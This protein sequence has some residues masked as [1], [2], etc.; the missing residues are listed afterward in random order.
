[1]AY[2]QQIQSQSHTTTFLVGCLNIHGGTEQQRNL[3]CGLIKLLNLDICIITETWLKED[4]SNE[5]KKS[6][7]NEEYEWY[8]RERRKQKASSGEGGIGIVLKKKVGKIQVVKVSKEYEM[9]WL[10][11]TRGKYKFYVAAIYMSPENSRRASDSLQQLAELE[12]DIMNFSQKGQVIMMGDFNA[13]IG[14]QDSSII[15]EGKRIFFPRISEDKDIE[16][17]TAKE[18]GKYL[19]ETMNAC[20]MVIMN[21]ID[22]I[23]NFTCINR[24]KGK[25]VV[26]YIILQENFVNIEETKEE[27]NI[28]KYVANSMKVWEEDFACISDHRLITVKLNLRK[29]IIK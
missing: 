26:D 8:S 12:V 4:R 17:A 3:F 24:Y 23:S 1:M 25:S 20:N 19:I 29:K 16:R 10:E 27:D 22:K 5:F 2:A 11:I 7:D 9:L 13:R 28:P 14:I 15:K 6:I 18:R 21:G